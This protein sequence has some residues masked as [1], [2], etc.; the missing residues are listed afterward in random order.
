MLLAH[1]DRF[2]DALA[3]ADLAVSRAG[4]DSVGTRGR[5]SACRAGALPVRDGRPPDLNARWFERGG[6]ALVVADGEAPARVPGLVA[7]LL[8]DGARLAAWPRR[9][10]RS[11][12]HAADEIAEEL[13]RLAAR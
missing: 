9:C 3:A 4:R 12:G 5:R 1:T 13:I 2:G 6:G 10:A 8:A 7:E 11:P